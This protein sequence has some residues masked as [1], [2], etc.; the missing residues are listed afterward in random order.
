MDQTKISNNDR[1]VSLDV[2]NID[3]L[4]TLLGNYDMKNSGGQKDAKLIKE[5]IIQDYY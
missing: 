3:E 5:I 2:T 1:L 4:Q